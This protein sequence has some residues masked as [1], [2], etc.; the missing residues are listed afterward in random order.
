MM[1]VVSG[2]FRFGEKSARHGHLPHLISF[3]A[4]GYHR[5]GGRVSL[6]P[7]SALD[8][9]LSISARISARL[10]F[11]VCA[12]SNLR[13]VFA[14][15]TKLSSKASCSNRGCSIRAISESGSMMGPPSSCS[16][17]G[18]CDVEFCCFLPVFGSACKEMSRVN[19][20]F[21]K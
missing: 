21:A 18:D 10:A 3:L 17:D 7:P 9:I 16:P 15:S 13:C 12:S 5:L 11:K 6:S 8:K 1:S 19:G 4:S 20:S 14:S 2:R